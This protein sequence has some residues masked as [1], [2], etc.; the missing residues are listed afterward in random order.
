MR[1]KIEAK[2]N[3]NWLR[4]M[5]YLMLLLDSLANSKNIFFYIFLFVH[6]SRSSTTQNAM[7]AI[8]M[9]KFF[10][11]FSS[12]TTS[13][14]SNKKNNKIEER[15]EMWCESFELFPKKKTTTTYKSIL[16]CVISNC[17]WISLKFIRQLTNQTYI[18]YSEK[19]NL[20]FSHNEGKFMSMFV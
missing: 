16:M 12:A 19:Q 7:Y 1:K 18:Y 10:S 8:K 17:W 9:I 13:N 14:S 20:E 3:W 2:L 4:P 6:N 15:E 5:N 11:P